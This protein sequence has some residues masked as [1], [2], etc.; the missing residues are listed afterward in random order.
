MGYV[1]PLWVFF[2]AVVELGGSLRQFDDSVIAGA[3]LPFRIGIS[4]FN[5][6]LNLGL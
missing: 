6:F 4:L 1:L 5:A 2:D 3:A